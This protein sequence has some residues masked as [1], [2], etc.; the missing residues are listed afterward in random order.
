[1]TTQPST[2]CRGTSPRRIAG[3]SRDIDVIAHRPTRDG[4]RESLYGW[5]S[6]SLD[7][8]RSQAAPVALSVYV[9]MS[10]SAPTLPKQPPL[11]GA[12]YST[13]HDAA[14]S[15]PMRRAHSMG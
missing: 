4:P 8:P 9:V 7:C 10:M 6:A 1:M 12:G 15:A 11:F 14:W 2:T 3:R 13:R 5:A